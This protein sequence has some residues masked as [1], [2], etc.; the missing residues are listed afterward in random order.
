MR[1][2]ATIVPRRAPIK[3]VATEKMRSLGRREG[4][5][6]ISDTNGTLLLGTGKGRDT[7]EGVFAMRS[8][9]PKSIPQE[10]KR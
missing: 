4:E 7:S 6:N 9:D 10:E 8:K 2:G 3:A 1:G 5:T